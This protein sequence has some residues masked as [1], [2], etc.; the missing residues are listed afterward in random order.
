MCLSLKVVVHAKGAA[1]VRGALVAAFALGWLIL[2]PENSLDS[3]VK[4]NLK[5]EYEKK[6]SMNKRAFQSKSVVE[7]GS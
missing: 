1:Q 6:K 4:W 2:R 5:R 3:I 7:N